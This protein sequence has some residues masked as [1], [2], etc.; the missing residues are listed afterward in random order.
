[1]NEYRKLKQDYIQGWKTWNN[2]NVLSQIWMP[3]GIGISLQMKDYRFGKLM[4]RALIGD[5]SVDAAKVFPKAHAYDN[6]YSALTF[7]WLENQIQISAALD[8]DDLVMLAV[9]LKKQK[10]PVSLII[11]GVSLWNRGGM[12]EKKDDM[13]VLS[14]GE[15]K[16]SVYLT[17]ETNQELFCEMTTPYLSASLDDVI[18][19]STGKKRTVQEIEQIIEKQR[20]R[21]KENKKTYGEK[22]EVYNAMQ[23]CLSWD[24]IY[25]P[26]DDAAI[27]T[28]SRI[29]NRNWGGY[30]LF[31]W[32]T[33]FAAIMQSL[34]NKELAYCNAI[35]IT[36]TMTH[37]GFVPN[38]SCQ[39]NFK[40][41]DRSQPP[42]GSMA[43]LMI[44]KRYRERWFLEEVYK[45]LVQWNEWYYT[46]RRTD[47]GVLAW[48]SDYYEGETGHRLET[49]EEGVNGWQGAAY[50]SGLD[51][52]PMYDD[53]PF[54]KEKN[55]LCLADVGLTGLYIKDCYC[56]AEIAQIMG[57]EKTAEKLQ[58]R[59]REIEDKMEILWDEKT[60]MYLNRREDTGEFTYRLS[61]FHFHALFSKKVGQQ[62]AR[63][64]INE[65]LYN[66]NEFWGEYVL[67]SI[68]RNDPA[69]PDQN[70]W[71]GRIW[72]PMNFLVYMALCEYDLPDA[73]KALAEKSEKLI[74]KEWIRFGHV[75]EN[76]D[77]DT[78]DGCNSLS[79]D[80]FY[81]WGGLLSFISLYENG[82]YI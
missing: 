72:A 53:V 5:K 74:M 52:S 32:D 75:H 17:K 15:R 12:I 80:A 61:P 51:N 40:S 44:Y 59:A 78:G 37:D 49:A 76:Y 41:F 67:P 13:L 18:G 36:H 30:V 1:M 57:D 77:G 47:T 6:S 23:T 33:Y 43:V 65:H 71:R 82:Y 7:D 21:W 69:Y 4:K 34:D 35:E 19:I 11:S 79:S 56:L 64:I 20:L 28:V 54:D 39:D 58:E 48:G 26:Q 29:W 27:T 8:G 3:D 10:K 24:T 31:C 9:Q 14:R 63:R 16:I 45:S 55:I 70:Y 42:V 68:A 25:N 62:R 66:E 46:H 73:Q 2:E 81:H 22:E 38:Y 60:G 50:E